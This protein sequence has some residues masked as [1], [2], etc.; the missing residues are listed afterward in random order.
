MRDLS[1]H[2]ADYLLDLFPAIFPESAIASH[3]SS[4]FLVLTKT[5]YILCE[6]LDSCLISS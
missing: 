1:L 2:S 5:S 4:D 3:F 6:A